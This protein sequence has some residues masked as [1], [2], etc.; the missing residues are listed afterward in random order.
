MSIDLPNV[1]V[2]SVVVE[3]FVEENL[4]PC[5]RQRLHSVVLPRPLAIHLGLKHEGDGLRDLRRQGL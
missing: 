4:F 3:V 2:D 5:L 1:E